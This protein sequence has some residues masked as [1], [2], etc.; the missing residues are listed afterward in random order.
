MN[1]RI[2]ST[3]VA[4]YDEESRLWKRTADFRS[5]HKIDLALTAGFCGPLTISN[6]LLL[7]EKRFDVPDAHGKETVEACVVQ[8]LDTDGE[9][10]IDLV[11][12]PTRDPADVHTLIGRAPLLGLWQA[13]NPTAY[14]FDRPLQIHSTPLDWLRAGCNGAV[15]IIPEEAALTFLEIARIGGRIAARDRT[16]A[17]ELKSILRA[18]IDRVPIVWPKS[19]RRAA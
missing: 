1:R 12:W 18:M 10:C 14:T 16:H 4:L 11:A 9:T 13:L 15:I 17:L 6:V 3:L 8:A 5:Q 19:A 2:I 7:P